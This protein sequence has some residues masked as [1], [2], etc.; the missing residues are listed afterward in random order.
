VAAVARV[1]DALAE[2]FPR[3]EGQADADELPNDV[4]EDR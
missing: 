3:L 1:G 4:S 2:H